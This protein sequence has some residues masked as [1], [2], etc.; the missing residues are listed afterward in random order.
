LLDRQVSLIHHLTSADAIFGGGRRGALAQA[1]C[2]IDSSLLHLEARFSHDKRMEK[3]T[4]VFPRTLVLIEADRG[5]IIAAF[6]AACPPTDISRIENAR[7]FHDFLAVRWRRQPPVPPYLP[8]IAAFEF[9]CAASRAVIGTSAASEGPATGV[10]RRAGVVLLRTA[11]DLRSI[12]ED[13]ASEPPA[14]RES[15]LAIVAA[16]NTGEPIVFDLTA[17]LFD[18][19]AALDQWTD[20]AV[21]GGADAQVL[22]VDLADSG[23][24]EFSR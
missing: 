17:E 21:F 9:A 24:V 12:F 14:L 5:A 13:G 8:D 7:Q 10:R 16:E 2:G 11:Y 18:L 4:G 23:L 15:R 20:P 22:I 6:T 19:L 3:V 1:L